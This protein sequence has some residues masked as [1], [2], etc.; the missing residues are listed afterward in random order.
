MNASENLTKEMP[1]R[2]SSGSRVDEECTI[3]R[4]DW[5][6]DVSSPKHSAEYSVCSQHTL[7][8][9]NTNPGCTHWK[10]MKHLMLWNKV[11][12][13]SRGAEANVTAPILLEEN[14]RNPFCSTDEHIVFR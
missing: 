8:R 6:F 1:G 7:S 13:D 3:A 9:H 12:H 11:T 10:A 2:I 14:R 5:I 4:S